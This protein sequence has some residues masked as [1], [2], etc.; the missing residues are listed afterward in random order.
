MVESLIPVEDNFAGFCFH[1]NTTIS[2][3]FVD[4][5][6]MYSTQNRLHTYVSTFFFQNLTNR[7]ISF[8]LLLLFISN[9]IKCKQLLQHRRALT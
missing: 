1:K 3:I 9:T 6:K 4:L 2:N 5:Y 7:H 8:L